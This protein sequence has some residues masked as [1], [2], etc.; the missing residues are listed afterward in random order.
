MLLMKTRVLQLS[1]KIQE[2]KLDFPAG[3]G[4]Y[5]GLS[6]S[7]IRLEIVKSPCTLLIFSSWDREKNYIWTEIIYGD[8]WS[9]DLVNRIE[10]RMFHLLMIFC[11][12][13]VTDV[14][15]HFSHL[16]ACLSHLNDQ[17]CPTC[18]VPESFIVAWREND[19]EK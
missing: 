3:L 1:L 19:A 12:T 10:H 11:C 18:K 15:L 9:I 7:K 14:S 2:S 17:E 4:S 6:H 8:C 13:G 5:V 16:L